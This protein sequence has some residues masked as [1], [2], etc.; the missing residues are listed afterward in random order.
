MQEP[1][2]IPDPVTDEPEPDPALDGLLALARDLA[3]ATEPGAVSRVLSTAMPRVVGSDTS[4]V[5][6]WD[7]AAGAL[8]AVA[9]HGVS[10]R[11]EA[12]LRST[13]VRAEVFPEM[14]ELLTHRRVLVVD[15]HAASA[16][17]GALLESLDLRSV[18]VAP[19]VAGETLLGVVT[20]GWRGARPSGDASRTLARIRGVADVGSIALHTTRLLAAVQHHARYDGLTG[21]PNRAL[22]TRELDDALRDVVPGT[23][24]AVLFCDL[25]R[26][27]T[28]NDALGHAAGDELLRQVAA[29][30]RAELRPIDVVGRLSGDEF[31]V[32]LHDADEHAALAVASR[33][34]DALDQ[35]FRIDGREVRVTVSVGVAVHTGPD[36]R[37]ER[38]L[39]AADA[40]MSKAKEHGRDQVALFGEVAAGSVVPSLESELSHAIDRGQLRLYF[41]PVLHVGGDPRGVV[42]GEALLRWAHPRLGLLGPGAFLPLAEESGLV[43]S[44]DLWAIDAACAALAGWT[45]APGGEPMRVAVNLASRTLLDPRLLPAVR[46]ALT[47]HGVTADQLHLELVETRSLA[48]MPGVTAQLV[49]LRRL[50]VRISLDD[51]GTGYS[52]LTWLQ[53]LPIDQI[54]IDR[55]FT[56]QLPFDGASVAV[57][58][59]VMA[60]ARELG[61]EVIAEGV[62]EPAQLTMLQDLGCSMVQGYLL[63][64]PSPVLDQRV[65]TAVA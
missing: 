49:E 43:S 50:G 31:A 33:V 28:V 20:A 5:M 65:R 7:P 14:V 3:G 60:L 9:S 26:F 64:R 37:G 30:L 25:D 56:K 54:K 10:D 47:E 8:R 22:F 13:D 6:L 59:G 53:S 23:G 45:T 17:L 63:G 4:A 44:L 2:E 58:R 36:G 32:R 15:S 34:V 52:T 42:G 11:Q 35:P 27:R 40:A 24:T 48:D 21:L 1:R 39:A 55:S 51:F 62:E 12:L 57:V 18:V 61:I 29:R 46:A 38:L 41:Q 16:P 19:L